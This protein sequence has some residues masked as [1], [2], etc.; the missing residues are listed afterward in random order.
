MP[1]PTA[2][3]LFNSQTPAATA[4]YQNAKWQTDGNVPL[5]KITVEVP[6]TG[7]VNLQ[8]ASYTLV[9]GD[10]GKLAVYNNSLAGSFT[11][12]ATPPFAQWQAAISNIGTGALTV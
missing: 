4:G 11:L 2:V 3:P 6:N 8:T 5:Q 9:A 10:C 1:N 12:P 7:K